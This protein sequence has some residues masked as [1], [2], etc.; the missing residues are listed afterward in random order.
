MAD[1]K[2]ADFYLSKTD[3]E[4]WELLV[5]GKGVGLCN[6]RVA[7]EGEA[8]DLYA[9]TGYLRFEGNHGYPDGKNAGYVST[10]DWPSGSPDSAAVCADY[11]SL[12]GEPMFC[13]GNGRTNA[14]AQIRRAIR[15]AYC[16]LSY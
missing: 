12:F 2:S 5:N 8:T 16:C 10:P 9:Y 4:L 3:D 15:N 11:E 6:I 14:V 1:R 13:S 7:G